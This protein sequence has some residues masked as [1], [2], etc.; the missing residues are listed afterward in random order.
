MFFVT[1]YN[2]IVINKQNYIFHL[3][4][5]QILIKILNAKQEILIENFSARKLIFMIAKLII[6]YLF[7][8][9]YL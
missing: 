8:N 5:A 9:P 2:Y 3:I 1:R 4:S 7:Q 6:S